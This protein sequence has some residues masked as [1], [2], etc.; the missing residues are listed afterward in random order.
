MQVNINWNVL[1]MIP[2]YYQT[3]AY[4]S[5][6]LPRTSY[7]IITEKKRVLFLYKDSK[8]KENEWERL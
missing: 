1:K 7:I 2:K 3:F 8:I 6:L 4:D 5:D